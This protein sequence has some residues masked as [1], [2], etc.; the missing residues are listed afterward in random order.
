MRL[1]HGTRPYMTRAAIHRTPALH[2]VRN[3]IRLRGELESLL[4]TG[5]AVKPWRIRETADERFNRLND[6]WGSHCEVLITRYKWLMNEIHTRLAPT[7]GD[8]SRDVYFRAW[9]RIVRNDLP[10]LAAAEAFSSLLWQAVAAAAEL[11]ETDVEFTPVAMLKPKFMLRQFI[12][13]MSDAESAVSL[14]ILAYSPADVDDDYVTGA[15]PNE[16]ADIVYE[17]CL[18]LHETVK[19]FEPSLVTMTSASIDL[20]GLND[21]ATIARRYTTWLFQS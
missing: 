13:E 18:S 5:G 2:L 19:R 9:W 15:G 6:E 20:A 17:A 10:G 4:G 11:L 21:E 1:G 8:S 3:M 7:G 16:L 14:K 12:D